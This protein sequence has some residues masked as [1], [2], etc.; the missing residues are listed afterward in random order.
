MNR[1]SIQIGFYSAILTVFVLLVYTVSFVFLL[2]SNPPVWTDMTN[3]ILSTR[4]PWHFFYTLC[5]LT[6]FLAAPLFLVLVV[7]LYDYVSEDK[8][9]LVRISICFAGVFTVLS[10]AHYFIQL[11]IVRQVTTETNLNL[12]EPFVQLNPSS[13]SFAVAML[14]WTLLL[15]LSSLFIAPIFDGGRLENVLKYSFIAGGLFC[16]LG[17]FG[18]VFEIVEL[19]ILFFCMMGSMLL[20]VSISLSVLFFRMHKAILS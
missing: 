14:G 17:T 1:L 10:S 20:L 8:K 12:I 13:V 9:V 18:Y 11:S 4:E 6:S 2:G 7:C 5:Q 3:Y 15:G 19:L 16:V